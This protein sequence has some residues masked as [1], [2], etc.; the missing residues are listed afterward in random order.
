MPSSATVLVPPGVDLE[1]PAALVVTYDPAA[2]AAAFSQAPGPVAFVS[3]PALD[4]PA[5]VAAIRAHPHPVVEVRPTHWDGFSPEPIAAVCRGV[6]AGFG[7]SAAVREAL[8][9]LD[10]L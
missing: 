1:A 9:F 6:I 10:T 7:P 3:D 5:A 8:A 2:P 4:V